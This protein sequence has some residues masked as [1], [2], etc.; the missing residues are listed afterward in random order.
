MTIRKGTITFTF[1]FD[2][3]LDSVD[4]VNEMELY[5]IITECREGH[6]LGQASW[7]DHNIVEIPAE[8]VRAEALALG[9]DGT[10]FDDEDFFAEDD[11]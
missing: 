10:F 9:N 3:T 6:M 7:G 8:Q 1:M 5:D 2:D 11:E 4:S